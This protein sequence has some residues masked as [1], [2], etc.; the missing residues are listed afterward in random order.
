MLQYSEIAATRRR[1]AEFQLFRPDSIDEACEILAEAPEATVLHAGG[2]DLV[3]RLKTG[4]APGRIVA[5]KAVERMQDIRIFDDRIEIGAA[6]SHWQIENHAGLK[7]SLPMLPAYVAGLGNIRV[8]VQGT[9]GGNILA[10]EPVYEMLPLLGVLD[11]E[12]TFFDAS[13]RSWFKLAARDY[14]RGPT[15]PPFLTAIT[16][17]QRSRSVIWDRRLRPALAMVLSLDWDGDMIRS[18]TAVLTGDRGGPLFTSLPADRLS[19]SQAAANCADIAADWA[20][21]FPSVDLPS[22]PGPDYCRHV[23]GVMLRRALQNCLLPS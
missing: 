7:I 17:P 21:L 10:G 1:I 19:R 2:I 11:A 23:A 18:G 6:A 14:R 22:G 16:I 4:Y 12:L 13:R 3:N 20:R 5:L 8:R 15:A 9:I